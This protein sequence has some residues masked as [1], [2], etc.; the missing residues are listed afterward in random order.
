MNLQ[1]KHSGPPTVAEALG[2][3]SSRLSPASDAPAHEARTIL[4]HAA[5]LSW[6]QVLAHPQRRLSEESSELVERILVRRLAGEPLAYV[7]GRLEFCGIELHVDRRALIPRPETELMAELVRRIYSFADVTPRLAIDIGTGGGC[8]ALALAR[9]FSECTVIA[10]DISPTALSLARENLAQARLR[11][12]H[13]VAGDCLAPL[14]AKFDLVIANLPYVP[15]ARL[16]ELPGEVIEQEPSL[17]LNGGPDGLA[18]YRRVFSDLPLLLAAGGVL[19]FEMD[20]S[21]ISAGSSLLRER[22][23]TRRIFV[24]NDQFARNRFLVAAPMG[25][26]VPQAARSLSLDLVHPI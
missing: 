20:E 24:V 21:N 7:V 5:G 3:L 4:K 12:V 2:D 18:V 13:L 19:V 1:V 8:L 14:R 23:R 17:A 16:P 9:W 10:S 26:P 6:S 15:E 22:L 25:M 11:N